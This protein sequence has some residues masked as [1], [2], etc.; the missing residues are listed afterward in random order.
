MA[1]A[2]LAPAAVRAADPTGVTVSDAGSTVRTPAEQ[3]Y[4]D[5][6]AQIVN[7]Y[8]RVKVGTMD[9]AA[10][11][12]ENAT[13]F[14]DFG[15]K[16]N[17]QSGA[18]ASAASPLVATNDLAMS[19]AAQSQTYYCG[20]AAAFE[21]LRF[22]GVTK[23]PKAEGLTQ[24]NLSG[25]KSGTCP[26]GYLCTDILN[27]KE[28]PWYYYS[29]YPHPM[30]STVNAWMHTTMPMWY[31]QF[32]GSSGYQSWLVYDVDNGYPVVVDAYEKASA[33][34]PHLVGHPTDHVITHW[35][36]VRGYSSTGANSR[37]ADS[38]HGSSVWWASSVPAYSWI[39]SGS[40]GLGYMMDTVPYGFVG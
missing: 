35:I 21:L 12:A 2:V 37:Y 16:S 3:A 36:S 5:R 4:F 20:P 38:V 23:G 24:S 1:A 30:L 28:T 29:G 27:P 25:P 15:L 22:L 39:K 9:A 10:F 34:T 32:D 13:F 26:V 33:S 17:V 19:Q 14:A 40:S 8:M 31:A 6:K 11:G 7:D 18:A